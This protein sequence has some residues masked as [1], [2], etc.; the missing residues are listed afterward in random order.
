MDKYRLNYGRENDLEKRCITMIEEDL[1][2]F[3]SAYTKAAYTYSFILSKDT[4][5]FDLATFEKMVFSNEEIEALIHR[6]AIKIHKEMENH[7][8]CSIKIDPTYCCQLADADTYSML[9]ETLEAFK[10]TKDITKNCEKILKMFFSK[11]FKS[12]C[13]YFPVQYMTKKINVGEKILSEKSSKKQMARHQEIIFQQ[14]QGILLNIK[15][16][17]RNRLVEHTIKNIQ[18]TN[19]NILQINNYSIA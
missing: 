18:A 4:K 17:I 13:P 9:K 15:I 14:V 12:I 16:N 2:V 11:T 19:K 10:I 1:E 5:G 6:I 8:D 7:L 3:F